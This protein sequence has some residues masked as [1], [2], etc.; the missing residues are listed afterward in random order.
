MRPANK[1]ARGITAVVLALCLLL[2]LAAHAQS[3]R[4]DSLERAQK[5]LQQDL[6][7]TKRAREET[8]NKKESTLAELRLVNQQVKLR[9]EL[10]SSMRVQ[11]S[12]LD[13]KIFSVQL[14]IESLENDMAKAQENYGRLM[15][16]IYKSL[17]HKSPTFYLISS[18]SVGQAY[19]RA[20]YF[21]SITQMQDSHMRLLRRTKAFLAVK[22]LEL[23]QSKVE[24]QRVAE[25]EKLE[26]ER[27]VVI[28]QEQKKLYDNLK[29]DELRL[30]K[31]IQDTEN[32]LAALKKAIRSEMDRIVSNKK[33]KTVT[34][35]EEDIVLSLT[36]DFDQNKGKFPW[37]MPMPNATITRH[38]GVQ[39]ISGTNAVV[40]LQ[41]IDITTLP[42]QSVRTVFGG[43]VE[44]V[45]PV[46]GQGKMIIISHG[47]Y[48]T[49]YAN[50]ENVSVKAGDKV[51]GLKSIGTARTD[52]GSG[53]TKL[54]FQV[55]KDRTPM[56]PEAW[57]VHKN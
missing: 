56:D 26:K 42:G 3:S 48:Y 55:Y 18:Q 51:E 12:E 40:D 1:P 29:V 5:R 41:G 57:L 8:R 39:S 37:P 54:H 53:E 38:F 4:L 31:M 23:E 25:E 20:Q 36:R 49:V 2:T 19:Q 30:N 21:K 14:T 15:V 33:K 13:Q 16:V 47:N 32:A 45:M 35:E 22:K 28:K 46:P 11:L 24:K 43:S 50:L 34:R 27:L 52:P 6:A 10:L 44:S 7:L 17:S 9:E